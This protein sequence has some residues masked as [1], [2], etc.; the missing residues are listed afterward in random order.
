MVNR[1]LSIFFFNPQ[2]ATNKT[3]GSAFLL[4]EMSVIFSALQLARSH[5]EAPQLNKVS[6]K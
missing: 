1:D 5:S 2:D 6:V 3:T 4:N